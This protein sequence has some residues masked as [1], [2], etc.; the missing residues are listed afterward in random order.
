M[1]KLQKLS[2]GL[3]L[4]TAPIPGAKT[5]AV[6]VMVAT[7]SKYETRQTSGLS[8]FLEHMFFKGTQKRPNT[9][10]ISSALD[11]VGG[12]YNAF[13]SKEYTGY[14][15]KTASADFP[16]A[17]DVVADML[18][19]SKFDAEEI[20]RE[21]GVII[22]EVNMYLDNPIMR[23]EDVF[24]ECLYGDT[25]AGWDTIGTKK[26]ISG[27]KRQDFINY[28]KSQYRTSNSF[29]CLAGD[30]PK[31]VV[32]LA[33][34]HFQG[35]NKGKAKPKLAVKEKQS[36]PAIKIEYK[37]TD[38]A[39]LSLGVRTQPH[40]APDEFILKIISTI[41]GGSMSSRLFLNLRERNGLCYYVRSGAEAYTDTGYLCTQAGVP[42]DKVEKA[43][44]IILQEYKRLA[45]ELVSADELKKVKQFISGRV[46]LQLEGPDDVANWYA[47]QLVLNC[48]QPRGTS[49]PLMTPA[50]FL[51]KI[52]KIGPEDIRRVAKQIFDPSQL[53]LAIIGPYTKEAPFRKL[54][55]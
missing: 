20:E 28:F 33:E 4:L 2:N 41:L 13:T 3:S 50:Q 51:A 6:L 30:L 53:N 39:H 26:N 15:V 40:N 25:P 55:K 36:R 5:A 14:W 43:I 35:W 47:R 11:R 48:Q 19:G 17:I 31:N 27:F 1:P 7:G 8:H 24:E 32:K 37:K 34:Q 9:Q 42:V 10:I 16:L 38:Q 52:K 21:K 45:S 49:R 23:I 29:V 12:E 22:E 18:L 54:L 44:A 46:L